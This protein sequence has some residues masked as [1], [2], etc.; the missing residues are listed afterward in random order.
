[1]SRYDKLPDDELATLLQQGDELAYTEIY[2]RYHAALYIHVF[3]KLR[4]REE[5]RDIVHDLFSQVWQNRT[6]IAIHGSLASYLF[7]AVRYRVFDLIDRNQVKTK[8]IDSIRK[9]AEESTVHADDRIREQQLLALVEKEIASLPPKMRQVF[10]LSRKGGLSH[11]QIAAELNLSEKTVKKQ[12]SNS[13][14][15]LRSKLGVTVFTIFF[16]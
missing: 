15:I 11:R 12:V 16:L 14:K 13:L 8:Y 7:A 9:F 5:S 3:N 6:T 10:E 2:Y 1:M 4:N